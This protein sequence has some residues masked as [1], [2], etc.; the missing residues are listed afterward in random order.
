MRLA[1][2]DNR[3]FEWVAGAFYSNEETDQVD[4]IANNAD[5]NGQLFGLPIGRFD[6][7]S[8]A[9]EFALFGNADRADHPDGGCRPWARGRPGT[10]RS[11]PRA[12]SVSS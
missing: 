11:S 1:S 5:P 8:T 7:P 10:T 4:V 6:L 3:A 12:G 9:K 2:P